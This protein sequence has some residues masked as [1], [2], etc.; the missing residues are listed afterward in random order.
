MVTESLN[1]PEPAP[2]P[3]D[4]PAIWELVIA[5]MRER[6]VTGTAKYGQRL[7]AGDGRKSLV[8]AYQEA[9]DQCVYLR[10]EIEE[11]KLVQVELAL[12]RLKVAIHE[13]VRPR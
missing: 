11:Q 7:V 6:D 8:D 12:L 10:K 5:D 3:A 4:G 1:T 13:I 9:L 2:L